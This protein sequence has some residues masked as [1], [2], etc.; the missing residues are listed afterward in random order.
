M[1][2]RLSI[3][4][5]ALIIGKVGHSQANYRSIEVDKVS[6]KKSHC[7][8]I[9]GSFSHERITESN[10]LKGLQSKKI[11]HV[12][13]IY[14][15]YKESTDFDQTKLNED[16][17][18]R[19]NQLLPKLQTDQ[20]EIVW[21]EQTGAKTREEA[22]TYFH[23]FRIYTDTEQDKSAF[24]RT[25][26]NDPGN[27]A[28][29]FTVDNSKGGTFLHPDGTQIHVPENAVTYESGKQVI[30]NYTITYRE[31]KNAAEI[32]F[33]GIPMTYKDKKGEYQFNSAGMYEI[34]GTQNGKELVLQKN[35]IIDFNCTKNEAGI[36]FYEMDDQTGEW[37]LLKSDLFAQQSIVSQN[38]NSQ[39]K[40]GVYSKAELRVKRE[41]APDS[42][43]TPANDIES[44]ERSAAYEHYS[45]LVTG[46]ESS[47]FGV[48][49]CDQIYRVANQ[50]TF[51]PKYLD[52]STKKEIKKQNIVCLIDRGVNGSF[53]FA[54]KQITCDS[55]GKN[56]FLLFSGEGE[57]YALQADKNTPV[58]LSVKEPVF[59]M[60]RITDKVK[61]S[62]ELKNYLE[63]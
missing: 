22:M 17:M 60:E 55:K 37:T 35:I 34:R 9:P 33:S 3:L 52:A 44:S 40:T 38:T 29:N 54:P 18:Y 11:R 14:T 10:L 21:I 53:S 12:E 2:L 46:L 7:T 6:P 1:K 28:Q 24:K 31:Y 56:I 27:P 20:P 49:N 59:L 23:G 61:T 42:Y 51:S 30:G 48:Y 4:V 50:I 32:T 5:I 39:A 45:N 15:H 57:I 13:L 25:E 16:R 43:E 47:K 26:L 36:N 58:D 19:L 63:I 41:I 8:E 62:D